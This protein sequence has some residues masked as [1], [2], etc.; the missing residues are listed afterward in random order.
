MELEY[1]ASDNPAG[2]ESK[3]LQ[4]FKTRK[5]LKKISF[6]A[7]LSQENQL[8]SSEICVNFQIQGQ[9]MY[10]ATVSNHLSACSILIRLLSY[11]STQF[12]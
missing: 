3:L 2:S 6:F 5:K 12:A 4:N 8:F 10:F 1:L 11:S 7:L 9:L